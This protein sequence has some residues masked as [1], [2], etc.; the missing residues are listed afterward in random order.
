MSLCHLLLL[1]SLLFPF[2]CSPCALFVLLFLVLLGIRLDYLLQF[3]LV[4]WSRPLLVY[5]F[6]LEL[7]LLC[8]RDFRPWCFHFHLSPCIFRWLLYLLHWPIGYLVLCSL[9]FMC[10]FFPVFVI[11]FKFHSFVIRKDTGDDLNLLKF[12]EACL[13]D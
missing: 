6:L 8:P 11:Y 7:F 1:W 3:F 4:F 5:T 2:L 9:V 12:I 13:M 10:L